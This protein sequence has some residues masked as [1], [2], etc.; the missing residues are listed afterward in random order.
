MRWQRTEK[1]FVLFDCRKSK[2]PEIVSAP[3]VGGLPVLIRMGELAPTAYCTLV[4][5]P[6]PTLTKMRKRSSRDQLIDTG[7]VYS[8][9]PMVILTAWTALSITALLF[10]SIYQ[11]VISALYSFDAPLGS[12][13][14]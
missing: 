3:N 4:T 7:V 14:M 5:C 12:H 11:S 9:P 10:A 8:V 6:P 13:S 2:L 1:T